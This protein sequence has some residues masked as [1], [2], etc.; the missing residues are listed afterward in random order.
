MARVL[1]RSLDQFNQLVLGGGAEVSLDSSSQTASDTSSNHA[2]QPSAGFAW[3]TS[4]PFGFGSIGSSLLFAPGRSARLSKEGLSLTLTPTISWNVDASGNWSSIADW[5]PARLP[6][7][8]DDVLINTQHFNAIT[9]DGSTVGSTT[10]HSLTVENDGFLLSGGSLTVAAGA[11]FSNAF[12]VNAATFVTGGT[13][14]VADLGNT[15]NTW[16]AQVKGGALWQNEGTVNDGGVIIFGSGSSTI[17][18]VAGAIFNLISDDGNLIKYG[19]SGTFSNDGTIEKTG[20][21]GTSTI[22]VVFANTGTVNVSSGTL[23]FTGGGSLGGKFTTSGSGLIEFGGGTFAAQAQS[24]RLGGNIL[25]AGGTLQPGSGNTMTLS[26][27]DTFGVSSGSGNVL[28]Y[29]FGPGTLVTSGTTTVTDLGGW[30]STSD[31]TVQ[32]ENGALWQNKGTVNDAGVIFFENA[33]S[34]ID[35][36][37]GAVF[38]MT[39]NDSFIGGK[40]TLT[41]EG[42]LEKTGGAGTSSIG[43][44]FTNTG[45]VSVSSGTL[46][47][48]GGGLLGGKF[49]T[50][51]TGLIELGGGTFAAQ[52]QSVWL[53]GNILVDGGTLEPGT[54]NT[55]TL[56]GTVTF[57]VTNAS[58]YIFG[59]GKLVTSGSTTVVDL[60][61]WGITSAWAVQIES[62]ALW[63]NKGT[64]N[65][66]GVIL[67]EG[68]ASTIDNVAGAIFNLTTNDSFVGGKGTFTNEGT[69]E[70]TGGTGTSNMG[71]A[72]TNTGT[73][74]VS[75]GMIDFKGGGLLGG[76]F[77]TSGTGIIELGGG[78]FAAQSQSVSLGGNILVAGGTIQPGTG[79]TITLSGTDTFGISTASG[80]ASAYIFGPGTLV[81][82]G[83]TTV[84]DLGNAGSTSNWAAQIENGALWRNKG[85]VNDAGV[86]TFEGL[87]STINNTAGAVFNLITDDANISGKGKFTNAG[88]LEKTGGTKTSTI[89]LDLTNTGTVLV[90]S[91]TL[92]FTGA[93]TNI[94]GTTISG[95]TFEADAGA[96]LS[97]GSASIVTDDATLI[98]NGAGSEIQSVETTLKNIGAG[99]ALE[100][101][102]DR[103]Y[104]TT[105]AIANSGTLQLAGGTFTAA[106][107]SD[108]AGS[109]LTGFGTVAAAFTNAGTVSVTS[110]TLDFTGGGTSAASGISVASGATLEIGGGT[111]NLTAGT[112]TGTGTILVSSGALDL[113]GKATLDEALTIAS[114]ATLSVGADTTVL[115]NFTNNGTVV[116]QSG[117]LHVDTVMSG[118]GAVT[119]DA[120]ASFALNTSSSSI[121]NSVIVEAASGTVSLT[122][123][124]GN[125]I[126]QFDSGFNAS[127]TVNGSGGNNTFIL[128]G[129]YASGVVFGPSTMTNIQTLVLDAGFN[130]DLTLNA[131][132][133]P[134]GATLTVNAASVGAGNSVRVDASAENGTLI[135]QL[136]KGSDTLI[137]GSGNDTFDFSTGLANI[138]VGSGQNTF[139][140]GSAASSTS[141]HYDTINNYDASNDIFQLKFAVAGINTAIT[142]GKLYAAYFDKNLEAAVNSSTLGAHHAVLFTPS[143]GTLAGQTFLIVDANGV[144]GYQPGHDLVIDLGTTAHLT[145][146]GLHDFI[147]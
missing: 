144:A 101:L 54:G 132:S 117:T 73:V 17:D 105:N 51:G 52:S 59:P 98:L 38:N 14:T 104:T 11:S 43:A 53:G 99:G 95:G 119:V 140:L 71:V 16:A 81:T 114:G 62:G 126:F 79:N 87:A 39:T 115:G 26:G 3:G 116:V 55:I 86:I 5:N 83:T 9:Y 123:G 90:S 109:T 56:T 22:G 135:F 110:G 34:T 139:V 124:S 35:N 4:L 23:D 67:F 147:T 88:T 46:D 32:V 145:N 96:K 50:S 68:V 122:G 142:S 127:D 63:Q 25:V 57:G 128:D 146:F 2:W 93:M 141:T 8:T 18:N 72:L 30:G 48:K 1:A 137:G 31:W 75:S 111:F 7:S 58:A 61:N 100:V 10:I 29:I 108:S 131:T 24:V 36:L 65:D 112:S 41:N 80:T 85:T 66:A 97:L 49:T 91:G 130:Y 45:T 28:S 103:G 102:G 92:A 82:S 136:G 78:T 27:A 69:L 134:N 42:T 6:G 12:T 19:G 70:K 15:T 20:G 138:T 64:V 133:D 47:F 107:L 113:V 106:S 76:K 44:V 60:G 21:T 74:S 89:S 13:T 77:S 84:T 125:D 120:G 40:G 33:A 94:S 129:D 121:G 118:T 37:V 143:A